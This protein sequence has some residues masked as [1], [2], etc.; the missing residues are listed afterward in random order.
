MNQTKGLKL[1][2]C[3]YLLIVTDDYEIVV[4]ILLYREQIGVNNN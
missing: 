4:R 1:C 2:N 3:I